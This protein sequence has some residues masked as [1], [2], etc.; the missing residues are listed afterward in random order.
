LF[1]V[2][3]CCLLVADNSKHAVENRFL[4]TENAAVGLF[5]EAL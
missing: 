3:G 4:A 1:S 2:A 5:F